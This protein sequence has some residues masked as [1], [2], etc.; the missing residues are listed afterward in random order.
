MNS[1]VI[2]Y[3]FISDS[4]LEFCVLYFSDTCGPG[5][6]ELTFHSNIRT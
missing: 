5:E 6:T 2:M 1:V 4:I 3:G